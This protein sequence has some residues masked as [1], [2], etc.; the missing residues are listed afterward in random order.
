MVI[1]IGCYLF[2]GSKECVLMAVNLNTYSLDDLQKLI[3]E[4][5][6]ALEARQREKRAGQRSRIAALIGFARSAAWR[7]PGSKVSDARSM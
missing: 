3:A 6:S 4:A 5:E 7:T 1:F 2:S